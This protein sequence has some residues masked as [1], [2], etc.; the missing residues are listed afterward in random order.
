MFIYNIQKKCVCV[1]VCVSNY[2][3]GRASWNLSAIQLNSYL[4]LLHVL[5]FRITEI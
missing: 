1:C 5:C 4:P 2:K 3:L